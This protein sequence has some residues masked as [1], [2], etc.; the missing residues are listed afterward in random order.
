M[1]WEVTGK[2]GR[3]RISQ[4]TDRE[5]CLQGRAD[6]WESLMPR[7]HS[8]C[9]RWDVSTLQNRQLGSQ[10]LQILQG[11]G[12]LPGPAQRVRAQGHTPASLPTSAIVHLSSLL[13]FLDAKSSAIEEGMP[14]HLYVLYV[15]ICTAGRDQVALWL[16]QM[17]SQMRLG[18]N[19]WGS[20]SP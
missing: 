18:E 14:Q 3:H 12:F 1:G 5:G 10:L 17:R 2:R 6:V 20:P 9:Y 16:A 11:S 19:P 4:G 15:A 13:G 7:Q 8:L